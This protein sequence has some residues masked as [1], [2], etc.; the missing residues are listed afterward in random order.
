MKRDSNTKR[1]SLTKQFSKEALTDPI[2]FAILLAGVMAVWF[3]LFH[4]QC[5]ESLTGSGLYHSDMKA[6]ILEM[7]G[8]DSGYSF[9]YPI[10]FWLSAFFHLFVTPETATA[11]AVTLLNGLAVLAVK[12]ALNGLMREP[13]AEKT[14]GYRRLAGIGISLVSIA[15]FF[16]SMVYPP[17]GMYLPGIL[18]NYL[19]VFTANP[20]HNA[21]YMAAR[22]FAVP[23]FLWYVKIL[24][25]YE[26]GVNLRDYL[27]FSALL[28]LATMA[29]PS[30]TIV[31]VGAAGLIMLYR[32]FRSR[33]QNFRQTVLLGMTFL[34]TFADLLYQF[35]GVFVPAE[36]EEGGIGFCLGSIWRLYCDNIPLAVGL[37]MGFPILVL[38]LNFKELK[39]NTLYRFSWQIWLMSFVMTFFL[40]EKGFRDKDFNFSWSYM[41]GIFFAFFGALTVLMR[42]TIEGKRKW[43]I[44]LQWL[45]FLWHLSCGLY[46]FYGIC[47]GKMYY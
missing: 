26:K 38:L 30:F 25:E 8:L 9:P 21:T 43:L 47:Q 39:T 5:V 3:C 41:Y 11:L 1:S 34:P 40:Y 2:L 18:Y 42:A 17:K 20:L 19:G 27:C 6:Y 46:Y 44:T 37:A 7:Q 36:G 4:R 12:V 10:L 14:P 24:D 33:F 13:L 22:P 35:R 29:K 31:L 23:A 45:A 32:L 15:L 16:V 28:L